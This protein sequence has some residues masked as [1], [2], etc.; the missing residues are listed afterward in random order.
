MHSILKAFFCT[1]ALSFFIIS[2]AED[3]VLFTIGGTPV[4]TSEFEYIY[5]KNNFSNK[6]DYSRAS[7]QEYLD[8]YTKF[9]LK[10]KEA[11]SLGIDTVLAIKNEIGSYRQQ[12]FDAYLDRE[13]N[14]KMA[15][16]IYNRMQKDVSISHIYFNIGTGQDE[17]AV[18]QKADSVY[19]LLK[20]GAAFADMAKQYSED[21]FSKDL[22]GKLGFYTSMQINYKSIEDAAYNTPAGSFSAPVRSSMGY[23]IIKVNE[24]RP[25][26]G[27]AKVAMI[28]RLIPEDA[29][30]IP[31]AK[32]LVDSLYRALEAGADFSL[33]ANEFS[34]DY[35]SGVSGGELDWFSINTFNPTFEDAAFSLK[36]TGDISP[37]VQTS[38]SWYI[39]KMLG[40]KVLGSYEDES[41]VIQSKL[42]IHPQYEE[43][44]EK[45]NDSLKLKYGYTFNEQSFAD[46]LAQL[47]TPLDTFAGF[48]QPDNPTA[49]IFNLGNQAIDANTL[50]NLML[51]NSF[52]MRRA[53]DRTYWIK[54]LYD[55]AEKDL[56]LAYHREQ[57]LNYDPE[58]SSL[59]KEYRDGILLFD[60]TE[61]EV[62]NKAMTDSAGLSMYFEENRTRFR[63][64]ERLSVIQFKV[65]SD[66][67]ATAMKPI[68]LSF[69]GSAAIEQ[70]GAKGIKDFVTDSF[71]IEKNKP[72]PSGVSWKTGTYG[73]VKEADMY[74][75]YQVLEILPE[76]ERNL[77][78]SKGFVI[79]GYQEKLEND[80]VSKLTKKYPIVVN[81]M[82]FNSLVK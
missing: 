49:I 38:K 8:L 17:K 13:I 55:K 3:K 2:A 74:N 54:S 39:I 73:P 52:Q 77:E 42:T 25:A 45:L 57:L 6:A 27:K 65:T 78:E 72:L 31:A 18:K 70:L 61:K 29:A 47:N 53:D 14:Q 79:A 69:S 50:G 67:A 33:L 80:W 37:P 76:R 5:K 56:V 60:L 41:P 11:E 28:K 12:L 44:M 40:R 59:M 68:L 58:M 71:M 81:E 15:E 63:M 34:E 22:G 4:Y 9:R 51:K 46:M 19:Q 32:A 43:I 21:N 66:K 24:V 23:H 35:A 10:V 62:W 82:T 1:L 20:S 64:P 7:L 16:D 36:N 75:Y 48:F 26:R 30:M